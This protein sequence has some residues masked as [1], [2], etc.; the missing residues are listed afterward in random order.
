MNPPIPP[1]SIGFTPVDKKDQKKVS[2]ANSLRIMLKGH[3]GFM[4]KMP[5]RRE[6]PPYHPSV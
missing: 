6:T 2:R 1:I 4:Q 3:L 5:R